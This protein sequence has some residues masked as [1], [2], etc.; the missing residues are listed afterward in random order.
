M[1][2]LVGFM[3]C[4]PLLNN[5]MLKL[6]LFFSNNYMILVVFIE[7][8]YI[9][10]MVSN[11]SCINFRDEAWWF[12]SLRV[13][14]LLSS[15]LLLFPQ[16]FGQYVLRPSSGV[17]WTRQPSWNFELCPLLNLRGSPVLILLASRT[18][19]ITVIGV[20]SLSF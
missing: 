8:I 6:V 10:F 13:F 19:C 18:H 1:V 4:Q 15:S 17:C 3:A 7:I 2:W 12:L 5:L 20:G 16:C 9:Q 11:I 14:G